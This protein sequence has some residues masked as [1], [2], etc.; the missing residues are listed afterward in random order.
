[1]EYIRLDRVILKWVLKVGCV[2]LDWIHLAEER[3]VVNTVMNIRISCNLGI[4]LIFL[5]TIRCLRSSGFLLPY[6]SVDNMQFCNQLNFAP[7]STAAR[8]ETDTGHILLSGRL[9]YVMVTWWSFASRSEPQL[10]VY[11]LNAN[12]TQSYLFA[13]RLDDPVPAAKRCDFKNMWKCTSILSYVLMACWLGTRET[14]PSSYLTDVSNV[15][16]MC[17]LEGK[18]GLFY[19]I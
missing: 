14:S 19:I 12:V 10:C 3:N 2:G 15:D 18:N 11:T 4:L 9:P 7:S 6:V 16:T 5:Q 17:F 1:V 8:V 13:H